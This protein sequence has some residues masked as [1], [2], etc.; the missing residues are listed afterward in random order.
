MRERHAMVVIIAT[1][2]KNK[3]RRGERK[4]GFKVFAIR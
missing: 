3:E 1:Q 4:L 2:K